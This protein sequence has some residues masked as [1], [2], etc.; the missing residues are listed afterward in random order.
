VFT[1]LQVSKICEIVY[2]FALKEILYD[3]CKISSWNT[4]EKYYRGKR[5]KLGETRLQKIFFSSALQQ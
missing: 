3:I 5:V 2:S 4:N 1:F